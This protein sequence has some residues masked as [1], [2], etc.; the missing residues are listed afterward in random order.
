MDEY[1]QQIDRLLPTLKIISH[2]PV[3]PVVAEAVPSP[4][5]VLGCGNYAAVLVHPE[6]PQWVVKVYA[7]GRS[8]IEQ[9]KMVYDRLGAHPAF[10][11]CLASGDNFLVLQRLHGITLYDCLP[12][13]KRI[14]RRAIA[15]IDRALDYARAQGLHPHD[16]HGRNVMLADGHGL[17]VDVSDF[18]KAE[19]DCQAWNDLRRAYYWIYRPLIYPLGLRVPYRLLDLLRASYRRSRKLFR[20]CRYT[21]RN[22]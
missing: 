8:G 20:R 13:G 10:S 22:A 4:W 11:Q 9:E 19:D 12:R 14:P 1:L 18:L 2:S 5:E 6:F 7:P 3:D 21:I 15:D 17:V 16:V